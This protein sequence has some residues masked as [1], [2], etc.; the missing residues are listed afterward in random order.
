[1]YD[2]EILEKILKDIGY[3]NITHCTYQSGKVPD[4]QILD[5]RAEETLFVEAE[6]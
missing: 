3:K 5:N 2:F 1:M 4:I 6:K